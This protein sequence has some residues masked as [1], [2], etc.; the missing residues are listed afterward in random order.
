MPTIGRAPPD[1][2]IIKVAQPM[3]IVLRQARPGQAQRGEW[4]WGRL[5]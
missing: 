5:G 1:K 2:V 3:V 4:G